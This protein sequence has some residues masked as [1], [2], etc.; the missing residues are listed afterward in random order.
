MS[1]AKGTVMF[2]G[3]VAIIFMHA[4]FEHTLHSFPEYINIVGKSYVILLYHA[5]TK[6]IVAFLDNL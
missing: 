3:G 4:F 2:F 6:K 1:A 5:V